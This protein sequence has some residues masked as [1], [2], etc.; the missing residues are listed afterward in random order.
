MNNIDKMKSALMEGAT[1][2]YELSIPEDGQKTVYIHEDSDNK[3]SHYRYNRTLADGRRIDVHLPA[4]DVKEKYDRLNISVSP[5]ENKPGFSTTEHRTEGLKELRKL[6]T[7]EKFY[8]WSCP[9]RSGNSTFVDGTKHTDWSVTDNEIHTL[10]GEL[11][12]G[13]IEIINGNEETL[14]VS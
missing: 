9:S 3:I 12:D 14:N 4:S 2:V 1:Q 11:V 8:N 7:D 10:Y 6:V 5:Y 13:V